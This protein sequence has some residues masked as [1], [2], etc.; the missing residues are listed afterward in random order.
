[1]ARLVQGPGHGG[2]GQGQAVAR[3]YTP[4]QG[5][6][7]FGIWLRLGINANFAN[8]DMST[9]E[10]AANQVFDSLG[11]LSR[12]DHANR[13]VDASQQA[14]LGADLGCSGHSGGTAGA[15][16]RQ[17]RCEPQRLGLQ[18]SSGRIVLS[19]PSDNGKPTCTCNLLL[20]CLLQGKP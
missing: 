19:V 6:A 12:V 4:T 7:C 9:A 5:H 15:Q 2:A 8:A 17:R 3:R 20:S 18:A 14:V 11:E 1:M 13:V 16:P 10:V